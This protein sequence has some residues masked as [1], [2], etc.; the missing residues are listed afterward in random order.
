MSLR[1]AEPTFEISRNSY[2]DKIISHLG[3]LK[4]KSVDCFVA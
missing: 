2:G 4:P 3:T 1:G